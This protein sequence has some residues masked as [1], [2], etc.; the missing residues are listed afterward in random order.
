MG[1]WFGLFIPVSC[2]VPD[3]YF[4]NSVTE[5]NATRGESFESAG[6]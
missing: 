2:L 6:D 5:F 3:K 1:V 4:L